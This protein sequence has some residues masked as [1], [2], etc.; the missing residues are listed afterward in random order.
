MTEKSILLMQETTKEQLQTLKE[1]A[2]GYKLI[3]GWEMDEKEIPLKSVEIIYGWTGQRSEELLTD[4][5]HTLKWV[6]G[7]AAGVDFLD[8]EKLERN[9][10]LLTN[11]SGIHSIPIAESVFGMLL[12][13]ARGIQQA[14]KNQQTKTWDQVNKLME[15]HGKTI[16]IVGTGK[17]GVEIGRLA[18]AFNM[19][20]IGV[21]RSGRDVDY[22]DLLIKQPELKEQVKQ[23]DIVVNILPHTDQTHYFFN[24]DIFSQMKEGTLFINV[25]RGPTVKTDDLIK[26]LDN[27]KLAFAGLD[28]FETEPLPEN[29]E[30]WGREDVLITPHITGIAEHFK[31]RLFAIFE[32]NLKAYLAGED[33]PRNLIDYDQQY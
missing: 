27:G 21:N 4:D 19:K 24:E 12:A 23:A 32:E 3:K 33:L 28:V 20:T 25:G 13:H 6:Q 15:L 8:L 11:G 5:K 10:I 17:I 14:V 18:K 26:A 16:L 22:M 9:K 2:P 7:K 30:L 29:S 1:L 31:K